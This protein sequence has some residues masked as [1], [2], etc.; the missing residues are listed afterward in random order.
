MLDIKL[1]V[2]YTDGREVE[3]Q[4]RPLDQ[5]RFEAKYG[6]PF[7]HAFHGDTPLTHL[8][9]LA[10]SA[11]DTTLT[12]EEWLRTVDGTDISDKEDVVPFDPESSAGTSPGSPA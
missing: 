10:W 4:V 12:F 6:V 8:Y 7:T 11:S 3:L 2:N 5:V 1:K 9:Y